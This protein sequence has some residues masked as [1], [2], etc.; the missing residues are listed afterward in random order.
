MATE[1]RNRVLAN[2]LEKIDSAAIAA[3]W[4][5]YMEEVNRDLK[6]AQERELPKFC[7]SEAGITHEVLDHRLTRCGWWWAKAERCTVLDNASITCRKCAGLSVRW[8]ASGQ[9]RA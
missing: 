5:T 8:G 3:G 4:R 2:P 9:Q 6:A 7:L 1:F